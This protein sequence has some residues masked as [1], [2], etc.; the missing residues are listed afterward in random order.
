VTVAQSIFFVV[1]A[2]SAGVVVEVVCV[3]WTEAQARLATCALG[4]E[5]VR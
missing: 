5:I 2:W 1:L 4:Q 3:I